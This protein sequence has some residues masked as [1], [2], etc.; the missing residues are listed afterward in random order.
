MAKVF[1]QESTLTSIGDAI[2]EKTGTTAKIAP[3]N[4]P[5]KIRSIETGGGGYEPTDRE[6][7]LDGDMT[8]AFAENKFN[9][10]IENY[11]D[12]I[13]MSNCYPLTKMFK[14]CSNL[15]TKIH[16]KIRY[17][18]TQ[19]NGD[20]SEIFSGCAYMPELPEIENWKPTSLNQLCYECM[21]LRE[22]PDSFVNAINWTN[23]EA[24][25]SKYGAKAQ[26]MFYGCKSLRK[27]PVGMIHFPNCEMQAVYHPYNNMAYLCSSLDE[28]TNIPVDTN[29][30][31]TSYILSST[32]YGCNRVKSITFAPIDGTV[33]WNNQTISLTGGIGYCNGVVADRI[34]GYNSG[35]TWDKQVE[36][37]AT[38]EALKDDPDWFTTNNY[39]SRYDHDSAVETINSLPATTGTGCTIAFEGYCGGGNRGYINTLTEEEIAVAAAKGWTVSF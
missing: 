7:R 2:R 25:T 26:E 10:V 1:I 12:R 38:Y 11:G 24:V 13:Y 15:I 36:D 6:L 14:N 9:W 21:S 17:S 22:V 35:I 31:N 33:D 3:G 18:N 5:A 19:N 29:A 28:I 34:T 8:M 20:V 23:F 39:Y 4:M 27:F 37:D 16:F 30:L 32:F